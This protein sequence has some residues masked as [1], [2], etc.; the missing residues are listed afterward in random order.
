MQLPIWSQQKV[1]REH[2]GHLVCFTDAEKIN[3]VDGIFSNSKCFESRP[4]PCLIPQIALDTAYWTVFNHIMIWGSLLVYFV[5]QFSYNYLL[6]G[7]YIGT[8]DKVRK[9]N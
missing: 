3:I 2:M 9:Y 7:E 4:S 5:L 6:N 8:L 1:V